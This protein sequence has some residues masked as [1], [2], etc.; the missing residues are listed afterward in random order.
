MSIFTEYA[1][2]FV[3]PTVSLRI[4]HHHYAS[5][6]PHFISTHYLLIDSRRAPAKPPSRMQQANFQAE[7]KH[8]YLFPSSH[9]PSQPRQPS[10]SILLLLLTV[11]VVSVVEMV[12]VANSAIHLSWGKLT[13]AC[14]VAF[15]KMKLLVSSCFANNVDGSSSSSHSTL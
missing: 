5:S 11:D 10:F 3:P 4:F 1:L 15:R 14:D 2:K 12:G 13:I 8:H 9:R 6:S 7:S